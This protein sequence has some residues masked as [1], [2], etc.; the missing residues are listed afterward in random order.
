MAYFCSIILMPVVFLALNLA[1][2]E[3]TN[4][5]PLRIVVQGSNTVPVFTFGFT[6]RT[7]QFSDDRN[8]A[9]CF[10]NQNWNNLTFAERA[11]FVDDTFKLLLTL[12]QRPNDNQYRF[13]SR[14]LTCKMFKESS[15]DTQIGNES[16]SSAV[17]MGQVLSGTAEDVLS[18][19]IG[20]RSKIAGYEGISNY[21]DYKAKMASEIA[22][23]LEL[24]MAVLEMKRRDFGYDGSNVKLLLKR[25]FGS[26]SDADNDA[27]ANSIYD[28]AACVQRNNDQYT[29]D[30]L[31]KVKPDDTN[32]AITEI[33]PEPRC[34]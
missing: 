15:F 13:S 19:R 12:H 4:N 23:Q 32:C 2:A 29:Q 21:E 6:P 26:P 25:Y 31:C 17:G 18:D 10:A 16:G 27:Y 20:F 5:Q 3:T 28:C 14:I 7:P 33:P 22:L 8:Q 30:C 11:G 1:W 24:S 34:R 9:R